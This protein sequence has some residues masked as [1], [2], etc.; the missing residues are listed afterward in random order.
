MSIIKNNFVSIIVPNYNSGYNIKDAIESVLSQTYKNWELIIIDDCSTDNSLGIAH[1]Y[2]NKESRI[3]VLVLDK[4]NGRPAIPRNIGIKEA[5]GNYIAFLDA[6]DLWHPQK[7]K[8]QLI[9]IHEL[10]CRFICS[11]LVDFSHL[12]DVGKHLSSTFSAYTINHDKITHKKL[13]Y[14]NIIP[15]SSVLLD[16]SLLSQCLFNEDKRYKAIEDYDLWLRIHQIIPCSI[17]LNHPLLFYRRSQNGISKGKLDMLKKN[18]MLYNEYKLN[19]APLGF[20][21][22]YLYL[23]SYLYYSLLR[24]MKREL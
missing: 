9:F 2:S 12:K 1:H 21:N 24:Q 3:K 14:K 23:C 4:N 20:A 7:L 22:R 5:T 8:I 11:K 17:K 6:D 18:Y 16:K 15:N 19:G 10:G 13:L